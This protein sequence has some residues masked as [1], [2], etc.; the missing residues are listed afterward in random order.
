MKKLLPLLVFLSVT[1]SALIAQSDENFLEGEQFY[2]SGNYAKAIEKYN[3][4]QASR[5]M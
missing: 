4:S 5:I 1:S 3:K 2:S